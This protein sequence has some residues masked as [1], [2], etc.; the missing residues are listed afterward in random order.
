M[1]FVFALHSTIMRMRNMYS[2][3]SASCDV[4]FIDS[5]N[6]HVQLSSLLRLPPLNRIIHS[7]CKNE[8]TLV[9]TNPQRVGK[10]IHV[11]VIA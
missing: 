6:G 11:V 10:I 1:N 9:S 5:F 8:G 3:Y 7:Y 4:S 2:K